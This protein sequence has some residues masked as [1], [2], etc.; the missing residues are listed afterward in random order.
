MKWISREIKI[1]LMALLLIITGIYLSGCVNSKHMRLG[2]QYAAAGDWDKSVQA[3]Q[4]ALEEN[5][6]D[7]E[8]RLLLFRSK[9]N[10][11]LSHLS[12]GEAL[13]NKKRFDEA[14]TEF[15]MSIAF[16][17]ANIKAESLFE[18]AGAMKESEHFLKKGQN[19]EKAQKYS[20]AK[21]NFQKALELNPAN[22]MAE[23]A[24]SR[25]REKETALPPKYSLK[26]K[27][28]GPISLRFKNT[29][30]LNIFEVLTRLTGINFIF[31]K[32]IKE[33]K[34]TFFLSD[35]PFDQFL[36]IFLRT[37]K[38]AAA[39]VNEK[40]MI[41]YP[42][43]PQKAK[44][45]QD[46]QIRTFYLA[47][48]DV[49]KAV[50][51]LT[52]ILKSKNISA[53][54]NLNAVVIR[55][56][57]DVIEVASKIIEANDRPSSEVILSVEI[58]EVSRTKE[59]QLGLELSPTSITVGL[60]GPTSDFYTLGG[61]GAPASGGAS[62]DALDRTSD[63]NILV[64]IPTATL[65]LLKRDGDTKTLAKPQIRVK[66]RGKAKIHIGE[67]IPLRTNRRVEAGTGAVTSDYQ[68]QD[69]GVKLNVEPVI[70]VHDE[71]TLKLTLEVSSI[72]DNVG[73]AA[74][75]QY[76]I[77]T[78]TVQ[79]VMSVRAGESVIIGGLIS[80]EERKTVRKVPL[81]GEIPVLG[82]L[83]SSYDTN[84]VQMD[85]LMAIT[86]IIVRSQEI[87]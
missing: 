59:Q 77:K 30:I 21:E 16:D 9:K 68:Y 7:Q 3:F 36:E 75:P 57:K 24:L 38:L 17:P 11:S 12:K 81:L 4:K 23:S 54:E 79:S 64:S 85:I 1:T 43:T 33:T 10:A 44:E 58:L 39:L 49:K 34:V 5:P 15:Q 2:Q 28:E 46:L 65:N 48:L 31:D 66:N 84:D 67:R 14:T 25:Y 35:V 42:D 56:P 60:G 52:K 53:N 72:G 27:K 18:E 29:P 62:L 40:T 63:K 32:D 37:N 50:A 70:N 87:P 41:I 61:A 13:L 26:L 47:Y 45:Y 76:S 55:A 83:F 20:Q 22:E 8:I 6:E 78:R 69:V 19:L 71:I 86:P 74:D 51:L 80:D 82:Y 73:T